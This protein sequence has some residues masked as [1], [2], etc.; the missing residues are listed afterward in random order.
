VSG[1]GNHNDRCAHAVGHVCRCTGC[2]GALHGW[3]GWVALAKDPDGSERQRRRQKVDPPRGRAESPRKRPNK[4]SR[5][6]ST[7]AARLDI[8]DWL[9]HQEVIAAHPTPGKESIA[10]RRPESPPWSPLSTATARGETPD[11]S[12]K[13]PATLPA[14]APENSFEAQLGLNGADV[15]PED[16]GRLSSRPSP[17]DE[18]ELFAKAMTQSAWPE[19]AAELGDDTEA[20]KEVKRQLAHHGWCDLFVGLIQ[21]VDT[22]GKVLNK[23]PEW[24]KRRVREAILDS[25]MQNA[26]SHVTSAVVDIVVDRVWSAFKGAMIGNI[27]LLNIITHED[28]LRSLRILAVFICPAPEDHKEVRE[29]ALKPLGDDARNI[30]TAQTKARLAK[31]F[32]EWM[33]G[34]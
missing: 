21:V 11:E 24:A 18:V 13:R 17:V 31:L 34:I 25:S 15:E 5:A 9:A 28:A 10:Y 3:Q 30:L 6:A 33:T 16:H 20:V 8:A 12:D 26:R 22:Y 14:G 23:I 7:D 4:K 19:I 27:P 2:S 32:D 29:R 1:S